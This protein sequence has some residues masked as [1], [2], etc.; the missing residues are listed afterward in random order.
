MRFIVFYKP[1][2]EAA[3]PPSPEHLA[4]IGKYIEASFKSGW[5]L[6]TDGLL[7]SAKGA[8]VRIDAGKFTVTDGPFAEAKEVIGGY[9]IIQAKS[10]EEAV[11]YTKSFLNQAGQGES[12]VRQIF[13]AS[14]A[15]PGQ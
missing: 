5:L 11:E 9:A 7:P 3:A 8:R 6:A 4:E 13:E 14:A 1:G 2:G 15:A 10:K 12:E